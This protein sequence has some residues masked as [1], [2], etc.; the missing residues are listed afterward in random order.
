MKLGPFEILRA[1][2]AAKPPTPTPE[3]GASGTVNLGGFL[4]QDEYNRDLLGASGLRTFRRMLISDGSVQEAFDHIA[5]PIKNADWSM[6]PPEDPDDQELEAT[7]L[8][9]AAFFEWL[10]QPWVEHLDAALEYLSLGHAVFETPWTVVEKE[11]RVVLPGEYDVDQNGKRHQKVRIV[12]PRQ[13]LTVKRFAPRLQET[14]W[15]WNVDQGDLVSIVQQVYKNDNYQEIEIPA[16]QLLVLTHKRRGDDFTGRPILRAAYK[17]WV[18]KEMLEKIAALSAERFGVPTPTGYLP[19]SMMGDE[20][21]LQRLEEILTAYR[22]GARNY[23]AF[24]GPKQTPANPEGYLVDIAFPSGAPPDFTGQLE[25]HR[26]EIKA[27]V[28]ARFAELGHASVGARATGDIQSVVWF[29]ALHATARYVAEIHQGVIDSIVDANFPEIARKPKLV[30]HDIENRNLA[31][32]A[33]AHAQLVSSGAVVADDSYRA[34][35]RDALDLPA[36]DEPEEEQA[37]PNVP[38]TDARG[39]P[40]EPEAQPGDPKPAAKPAPKPGASK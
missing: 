11:L 5:A 23:L 10:E 32:Y 7:A 14:I 8:A 28:L 24:S 37:D 15:R 16:E 26:G 22:S 36:E 33:A 40:I 12:P 38:E 20:Q 3:M 4:T 1:A 27:A 25:Y 6:E 18:F 39:R 17:P 35:L 31:E 34:S 13:Y 9:E 21:Q 2:R 29:A 19:A 30:V